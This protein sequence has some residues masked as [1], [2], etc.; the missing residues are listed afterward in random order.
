MGIQ[1]KSPYTPT[2][3]GNNLYSNSLNVKLSAKASS[4]VNLINNWWGATDQQSINQSIYDSKNDF[5]L[6]KVN[7]IPFLS[8]AN[9]QAMP[10]INAPMST[11]NPSSSPSPIPSVSE[12]P[13]V[14][15]I[16]TIL[17]IALLATVVHKRKLSILTKSKK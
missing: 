4:E 9:L 13:A 17:L 14:M 7:F 10:D 8:S 15:I 11:P 5:N 6:G 16:T 3:V 1:I 12:F 2:I